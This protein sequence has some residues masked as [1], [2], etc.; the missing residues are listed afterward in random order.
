MWTLKYRAAEN[1]NLSLLPSPFQRRLLLRY[2][3]KVQI[4]LSRRF[5][6]G[7]PLGLPIHP[8][9]HNVWETSK[10]QGLGRQES[11]EVSGSGKIQDRWLPE[12]N[13]AP[14]L[15]RSCWDSRCKGQSFIR[16]AF[17]GLGVFY[18][19]FL[20]YCVLLS[21]LWRLRSYLL[22]P[23]AWVL[24]ICWNEQRRKCLNLLCK[25][26]VR[27]DREHHSCPTALDSGEDFVSFAH[28]VS[29][30]R[31]LQIGL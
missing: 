18:P 27:N 4:D 29:S 30:Y 1:L 23:Y 6:E 20:F 14:W 17:P 9:I 3:L 2:P 21:S 13:A 31:W 5:T 11:R 8:S 22:I 26:V 19:S 16:A 15:D 24:K 10:H 25:R 12:Q 28:K 7:M